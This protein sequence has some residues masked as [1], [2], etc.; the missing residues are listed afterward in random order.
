MDTI[1]TVAERNS[2]RGMV[3]ENRKS[4]TNRE[5]DVQKLMDI[6]VTLAERNRNRG[7]VRKTESP[8]Q[9]GSIM[10]KN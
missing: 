8:I 5:H 1:V 4:N 3:R 2:N 7:V 6:I 10:S 9:I